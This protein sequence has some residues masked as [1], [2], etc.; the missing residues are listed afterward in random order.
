V[1]YPLNSS[2]GAAADAWTTPE[3]PGT[4]PVGYIPPSQAV[5]GTSPVA[6]GGDSDPGGRD[7][8]ADSVAGAVANAQARYGELQGDT[9]GAGSTIGD[10]MNLPQPPTG[11]G[12]GLA[13]VDLPA[14]GLGY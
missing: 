7:D 4:M 6:F 1:T 11:A 8:V 12:V 5:V 13:D 14:Q 3:R 10:V 9:Y 2:P